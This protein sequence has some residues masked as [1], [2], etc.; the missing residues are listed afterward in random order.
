MAR[1]E[2]MLR[3]IKD[4]KI[5]G[6]EYHQ[7]GDIFH[8]K[9]LSA[10]HFWKVAGK[11]DRKPSEWIEHD[12]FDFG[13]LIDDKWLF[14]NDVVQV[15]DLRSYQCLSVVKSDRFGALFVTY[16]PL[17]SSVGY[18]VYVNDFSLIDKRIEIVGNIYDMKF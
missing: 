9:S 1:V 8:T 11:K 7:G 17:G 18:P 6:Y 10:E 5:V 16:T 3:L 14:E 2:L 15:S 12:S 13:V 4:G